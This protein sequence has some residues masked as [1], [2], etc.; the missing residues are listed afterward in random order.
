MLVRVGLY[1]AL[2]VAST[3]GVAWGLAAWQP[4]GNFTHRHWQLDEPQPPPDVP[5]FTVWFDLTEY[6]RSGT[7]R[8]L[9]MRQAISHMWDPRVPIELIHYRA[10]VQG[11]PTSSA[12]AVPRITGF[13]PY[14]LGFQGV[15]L[16][17]GWPML[18]H[19]C[20]LD[21]AI[22]HRQ[23]AE[24]HTRGGLVLGKRQ[25]STWDLSNSRALPCRPVWPGFLANSSFYAGAWF[26]LLGGRRSVRACI[27]CRRGLCP[28][29]AYDLRAT[30]GACPECGW[31]VPAS[32]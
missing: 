12:P 22:P 7:V 19:W 1:A 9:W 6:T 3:W 4:L 27:R 31:G 29:C 15:Q 25:L 23:P 24:C 10:S 8:R 21:L 14:E 28:A 18:S 17:H 30:P 32:R 16:F 2:G 13:P 5:W 26:L 20:D 11:R